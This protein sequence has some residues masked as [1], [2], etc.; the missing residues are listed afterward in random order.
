[1][2]HVRL[3][4]RRVDTLR[5]YS[6]VRDFRDTDLKGYGIQ[7]MPSGTK[8][9][10]IHSQREGRRFWKI[11]GDAASITEAEARTGPINAGGDPGG[12]GRRS[13]R[14]G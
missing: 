2:P 10:F 5:R 4:Q 11:V 8:R 6:F 1:M 3:N 13:R 7:V 12:Q 9:Y 14:F